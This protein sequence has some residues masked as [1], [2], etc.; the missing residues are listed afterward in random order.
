MTKS[1]PSLSAPVVQ[2]FCKLCDWAREVWLNHVELFDNNQR[3][4]ELMNSFAAEEFARL[5]II[6]Q[7]YSLL[8][9]V[10]LHDKAVMDGN[11]TLASNA[12]AFME[13]GPDRMRSGLTN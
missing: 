12:Y 13:T 8:Q 4:A 11:K 3:E 5:S 7:E 9:I 6:S 1:M 10:K 2:E